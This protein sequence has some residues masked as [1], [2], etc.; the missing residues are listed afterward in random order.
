MLLV[1]PS[2][3][4][5]DLAHYGPCSGKQRNSQELITSVEE[6]STCEARNTAQ[7]SVSAFVYKS[8]CFENKLVI[9]KYI[10]TGSSCGDVM[11]GS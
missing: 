6:V 10:R 11:K 9:T 1:S 7:V 3:P 8:K 5:E 4:G 2:H